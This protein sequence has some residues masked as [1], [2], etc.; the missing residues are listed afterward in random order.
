MASSDDPG[1]DV[2]AYLIL[3]NYSGTMKGANGR[4]LPSAAIAFARQRLI[5][6][7]IIQKESGVL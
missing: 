4:V 7:L 2:V 5:F 3:G 6:L 1:R